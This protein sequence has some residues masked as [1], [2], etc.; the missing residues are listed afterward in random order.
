METYSQVRAGN[1][2]F[3]SPMYLYFIFHVLVIVI[4]L[5]FSSFIIFLLNL[6]PSKRFVYHV[7]VSFGFVIPYC[8][9]VPLA[10]GSRARISLV[11]MLTMFYDML[12]Y[13]G[14]GLAESYKI[15][16]SFSRIIVTAGYGEEDK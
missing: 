10:L 8:H 3:W 14:G 11:A 12:P 4:P 16:D 6:F 13:I 7:A 2:E 5:Y 15:Y 9:W 1:A